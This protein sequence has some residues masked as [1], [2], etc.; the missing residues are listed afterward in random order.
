MLK[1][2]SLLIILFF[3]GCNA[4]NSFNYLTEDEYEELNDENDDE[5]EDNVPILKV[6][7]WVNDTSSDTDMEYNGYFDF[8]THMYN[9]YL[10]E[11]MLKNVG[12]E[13]LEVSSA[14]SSDTTIITIDSS[15]LSITL[16]ENEEANLPIYHGGANSG[17]SKITIL[18]NCSEHGTFVFDLKDNY[19]P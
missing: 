10:G 15:S 13:D 6:R 2:F 18:S 5:E 1:Y 9:Q 14:T 16:K 8:G 3:L 4:F 12:K 19:T 17:T 7:L 11:I